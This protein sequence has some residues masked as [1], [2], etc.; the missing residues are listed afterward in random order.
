MPVSRGS[1][2]P[3]QVLP[4]DGVEPVGADDQVGRD[5]AAVAQMHDAVAG[6]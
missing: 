3:E 5:L 4:H 2:R 6:A 1:E